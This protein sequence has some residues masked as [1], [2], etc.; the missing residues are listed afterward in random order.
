MLVQQVVVIFSVVVVVVVS[1]EEY[2]GED[3]DLA[4]GRGEGGAEGDKGG[5]EVAQQR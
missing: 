3:A 4:G 2:Y 5:R 1:V